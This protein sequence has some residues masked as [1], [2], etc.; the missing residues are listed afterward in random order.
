MKGPQ[1]APL[2]FNE[3][4]WLVNIVASSSTYIDIVT[5][6][7]PVEKTKELK[8]LCSEFLTIRVLIL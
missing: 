1:K 3:K 6:R 4:E 7:F 8:V 2:K 5:I